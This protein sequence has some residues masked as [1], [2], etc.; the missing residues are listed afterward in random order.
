MQ[1][2][3]GE[4][5]KDVI[6]A[7]SDDYGKYFSNTSPFYD[8]K[9]SPFNLGIYMDRQDDK[10][11]ASKYI[12]VM[13]AL[14]RNAD[15]TEM[16]GEELPVI[17][18]VSRFYA[19]LPLKMLKRVLAGNDYYENP[20]MIKI[21]N[22]SGIEWRN[23]LK[24]N[25]DN[26]KG[27]TEESQNKESDEILF[28]TVQ[29]IGSIELSSKSGESQADDID[30]GLANLFGV[31][32]IL[33]FLDKAKKV[34]EKNL[35]KQ[36]QKVEE[37]LN[38]KIKGRIL[39]QKQLKY[40][41]SKG[42]N[43]KIYCAYN[44]MTEDIRENQIIK[45]A[46]Y[47]CKNH[48]IGAS[49]EEDIRFCMNAL[50][51]VPL[52]KCSVADFIG[53]KNNG[54]FRQYKDALVA[55]KKIIKSYGVLELGKKLKDETGKESRDVQLVSGEVTPYYIDINL[56]FEYYCRAIFKDAIEE[57]NASNTIKFNLEKKQERKLFQEEDKKE[58]DKEPKVYMKKYTPDIVVTY[59]KE[60]KVVAVF[61]AKNSKLEDQDNRSRR[62][63]THQIMFYMKALGC[64]YGGLISPAEK[65]KKQP[66]G[67]K[68]NMASKNDGTSMNLYYIPLM[69]S[70]E[71]GEDEMFNGFKKDVIDY[72]NEIEK[73][74]SKKIKKDIQKPYIDFKN[75]FESVFKKYS[76]RSTIAKVSLQEEFSGFLTQERQDK[77]K[78]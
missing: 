27:K 44:K 7:M 49:L 10:P 26:E 12:G 43:Q 29:G 23:L 54:A 73:D 77:E 22:Y 69:F 74:Y 75:W 51:N 56:L 58:K 61:D 38:C 31:F 53:L 78:I 52:K 59:G 17:K 9:W 20:D 13:P 21:K 32:E 46:L 15:Q 36:S 39:I 35:K 57:F 14:D 67:W 47:L 37:N 66:G 62:A 71:T 19:D 24:N 63:R 41:T 1:V 60:E 42:Q 50:K 72:L 30:Y 55:A 68:L 6:G 18:I 33:D 45:Y 65:L 2:F 25:G 11:K 28:G 64:D 16:F 70:K 8:E 76:N 3:K 40:N 4:D 48:E 5:Y 34:C